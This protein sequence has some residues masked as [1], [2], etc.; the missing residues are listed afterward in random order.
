[1]LASRFSHDHNALVFFFFLRS[2]GNINDAQ[3][4]YFSQRLLVKLHGY[5]ATIKESLKSYRYFKCITLSATF[6]CKSSTKVRKI[7]FVVSYL[8]SCELLVFS[9]S[10]EVLF[11]IYLVSFLRQSYMETLESR[12]HCATGWTAIVITLHPKK[13]EVMLIS[14]TSFASGA[15]SIWRYIPSENQVVHSTFKF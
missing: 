8:L 9:L 11:S 14:K 3:L 15:Y 6:W 4:N 7:L 1:M 13:S 2:T 10:R 5:R 12:V